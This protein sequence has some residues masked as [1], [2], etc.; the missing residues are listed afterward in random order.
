M[1]GLVIAFLTF[2][3]APCIFSGAFVFG[4][5]SVEDRTKK[6][7][8]ALELIQRELAELKQLNQDQR[9]REDSEEDWER[10]RDNRAPSR[11]PRLDEVKPIPIEDASAGE[12]MTV[13]IAG[14]N[15]RFRWCPAGTFMMGSPE[16]EDGRSDNETQ[17]EVTLTRG[18]WLAETETTQELWEAIMGDNRSAFKGAVLPVECVSWYDC[19]EFIDKIQR[20]APSGL[21]FQLPSEAHWEYACRA[22]T[23]GSYNVS[24]ASLDSLA[25]YGNNS[26]DRT[27]P[28][29]RKTPNAWG[30]YDMHGNV[31][32]WCSDRYGDYS[33][34]SVTNP[35]GAGGGFD[36]VKR[37]GNYCCDPWGSRSACR[38]LG[39][40]P[41]CRVGH[42]G[43]RLE[44]DAS[45][46]IR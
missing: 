30:F 16:D 11:L 6:L 12:V 7:E 40:P 2:F 10:P 43:F 20:Y 26:D 19:Q 21:N 28:V 39:C 1:L 25:W 15:V 32:E 33:I 45:S 44:L 41:E 36:R 35:R 13:S 29:G 23:T 18:F 46:G 14:V 37:G 31:S 17:H 27:H 42:I 4:Q 8:D 38:D 5:N 24:G 22:G 3:I 34:G 9:I